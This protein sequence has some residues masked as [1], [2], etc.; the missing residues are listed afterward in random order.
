MRKNTEKAT[1]ELRQIG[2]RYAFIGL[3]NIISLFGI[4]GC[5]MPTHKDFEKEIIINDKAAIHYSQDIVETIPIQIAQYMTKK[6]LI[7]PT[8]SA[9][10]SECM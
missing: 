1:S 2:L 3:L 4:T 10:G 8:R 9:F 5:A 7:N 6:G